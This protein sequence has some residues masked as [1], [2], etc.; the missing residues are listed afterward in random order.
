MYKK[1][2]E[3]LEKNKISQEELVHMSYDFYR[4]LGDSEIFARAQKIL[5]DK[6]A[7]NFLS[8]N[9]KIYDSLKRKKN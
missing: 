2:L 8:K 1:D 3:K 5:K 9:N 4:N 6:T 7:I